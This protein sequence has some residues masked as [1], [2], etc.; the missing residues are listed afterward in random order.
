MCTLDCRY[1]NEN[2]TLLFAVVDFDIVPILGLESSAKFK[3]VNP[4]RANE[5]GMPHGKS[6]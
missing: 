3:I 6:L 4:P 2:K 1:K 5:D